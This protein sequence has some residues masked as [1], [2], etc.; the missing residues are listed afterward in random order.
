MNAKKFSDAMGELD[1]KYV[2]EA[3]RRPQKARKP[4][5]VK[6]SVLAACLAIAAVLGVARS[7][8]LGGRTDSVTLESGEEL[9]FVRA[10]EVGASLD[11]AG[12]ITTR[13]LTA[14]EAAA[15]FPGLTVTGHATCQTLDADAVPE[16]IGLEGQIGEIKLV[17]STSDAQL[18]DAVV[19]GTETTSRV[20][21][22]DVTAGYFLTD[23]NSSGE[24]YVIYYADFAA[25]GCRV[26]LEHTGPYAERETLK[27]QLAEVLQTIVENGGPDLTALPDADVP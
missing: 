9:V 7:G 10:D 17:V 22:T 18:L 12:T 25:G 6:W 3:L 2:E 11:I 4:R 8:L 1:G 14:E 19:E 20:L 5:W 27:M 24:R 21:G 26:Y 15:V 13:E 23:R 16:L